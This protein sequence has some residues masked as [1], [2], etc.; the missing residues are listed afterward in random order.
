MFLYLGKV[1][2]ERTILAH[3]STKKNLKVKVK[4]NFL[5]ILL[6]ITLVQ[7]CGL[8]LT[9]IC[10]Y[11]DFDLTYSRLWSTDI[12]DDVFKLYPKTVILIDI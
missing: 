10:T 7:M 8:G 3:L 5:D 2:H 9:K 4:T 6:F 11:L 1:L 12:S